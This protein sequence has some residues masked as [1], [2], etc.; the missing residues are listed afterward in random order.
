MEEVRKG[1]YERRRAAE[2]KNFVNPNL[3]P[4]YL[5]DSAL[6]HHF[7]KH[8]MSFSN[9]RD[10]RWFIKFRFGNYLERKYG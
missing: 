8:C 6:S 4:S 7:S 10:V 2:I 5:G 3:M 9:S 1:G